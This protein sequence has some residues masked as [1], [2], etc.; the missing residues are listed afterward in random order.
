MFISFQKG[1]YPDD[2]DRPVSL[3][4]MGVDMFSAVLH[5]SSFLEYDFF[6]SLSLF[7]SLSL[8]DDISAFQYSLGPNHLLK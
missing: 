4:F 2:D 7:V 5:L 1:I 8:H 3:S 6:H